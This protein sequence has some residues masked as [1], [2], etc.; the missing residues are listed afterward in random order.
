[1]KISNF[2][3]VQPYC[4]I[5]V[6]KQKIRIENSKLNSLVKENSRITILTKKNAIFL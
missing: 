3:Y 6:K 5:P 1:M 2:H 4:D